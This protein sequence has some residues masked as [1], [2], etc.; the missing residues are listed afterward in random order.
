MGQYYHVITRSKNKIDV[1]N[2]QSTKYKEAKEHNDENAWEHYHGLKLMEHS[3]W[4]CPFCLAIAKKIFDNPTKVCWCGDYA[5][6]QECE[7]YGFSY[8]DVWNEEGI[9][10]EETDFDLSSVNYLINNDKKEY[11]DLKKYYE[12]SVVDGWCIFPVSLL[13]AL[14][15]L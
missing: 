8:N 6:E 1:Y 4:R 11:V 7:S 10:F 15:N 5:T 13:T 9:Y 12:N 3:W 2:V 14:G